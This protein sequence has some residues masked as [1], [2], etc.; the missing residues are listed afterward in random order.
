MVLFH[1]YPVLGPLL[2][3]PH[4]ELVP[5]VRDGYLGVDLFF[6]LSGFVLSF[7]YSERFKANFHSAVIEFFFA[8]VWRIYPLHWVCLAIFVV[9]VKS[10]PEDLWGPGP[11]TLNALIASA[12]L[13]QN[14]SSPTALGWNFPAWSLSAEWSAYLIFPFLTIA[15]GLVRDR[16]MAFCLAL[17]SLLT[18]VVVRMARGSVSLDRVGLAGMVR[19]FFEFTAGALAWQAVPPEAWQAENADAP[20]FRR[21]GEIYT[22]LGGASL[23]TRACHAQ[24]PGV[25]TIRLHDADPRMCVAV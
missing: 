17:A 12:G 23:G 1:A 19:C 18:L 21:L 11:F 4:R 14:W 9:L 25:G 20:P 5:V 10:V 3:G 22:A 24:C 7:A 13:V 8:R 6:V 2:G 15:V 16:R